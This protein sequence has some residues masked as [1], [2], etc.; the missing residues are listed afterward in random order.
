M[1]ID[2]NASVF[3]K[4]KP[5][6]VQMGIGE[7]EGDGEGRA[8]TVEYKNF[9]L[10]NTY[11]PNSGMKVCG[12]YPCPRPAFNSRRLLHSSTALITA[13]RSGIRRC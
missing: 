3:T 9:F 5:E 10:I 13:P 1:C 11:V 12:R 4:V 2:T 7:A 8:I 6:S